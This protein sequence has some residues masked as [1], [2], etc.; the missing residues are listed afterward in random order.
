MRAAPL[1][2]GLRLTGSVIDWAGPRLTGAGLLA[3]G[4]AAAAAVL[5]VD[6][7]QSM[8]Y[9]AFT[10]L[11][12]LLLLAALGLFE[13][14]AGLSARRLLPRFAAA[15]QPLRYA[16]RVKNAGALPLLGARVGEVPARALPTLE[17]YDAQGPS[18][19]SWFERLSGYGRWEP[20]RRRL[21]AAWGAP[22]PLPDLPPGSEAEVALELTPSARGRL[23]F[24]EL[25]VRAP[26]PLGLLWRRAAAAPAE[27]LL[28]LP[29]R[30][31]VP[32]LALP[33]KR[34]YQAGGVALS[35]SVGES[36]EFV[37]LR[38]YRPGDPLRRVHWKSWAKR[39]E[40]VVKEFQDEHFVRHALALDTFASGSDPECFEEAV[41]VAASFAC[42]LL[43]QDSLLDLLFVADRAYCLS[44]GRGVGGVEGLLEAL[45]CAVTRPDSSVAVLEDSIVG[46]SAALSGCLLVL[47]GYDAP[48]RALVRRLRS[49][50]L[51]PRALV[52]S[53]TE[54]AGAAADGAAWLRPGR[55]AEDLARL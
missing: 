29:R 18:G 52:V 49:L 51:A 45:A 22:V 27:S 46:R 19:R 55:I 30:Y 7:T 13:R 9:Q 11:T 2:R 1:Y 38:D 36:E 25:L 12:A 44:A 26:E 39:G 40:P 41:S 48:R 10:F 37:A 4:G 23:R 33:G 54:P 47:L 5:G 32:R 42:T 50:G 21:L 35:S 24:K 53:R 15:G 34:R 6:T 16:V 8:A 28:V 20:V 43:T 3:L 14:Q 31:P 17:E